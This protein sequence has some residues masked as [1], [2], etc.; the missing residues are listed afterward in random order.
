MSL[1]PHFLNST[2]AVTQ[3]RDGINFNLDEPLVFF[4]SKWGWLRT[5][6]TSDGLSVPQIFWNIIPPV[7]KLLWSGILHDGCYR[8]NTEQL[9]ADGTWCKVTF[10]ESDS[11]GLL[12][13]AARSLGGNDVEVSTIYH[14]LQWFGFRAFSDDR[15]VAT[16]NGRSPQ[17]YAALIASNPFY[18]LDLAAAAASQKPGASGAGNSTGAAPD[19]EP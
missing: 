7:G 8:N 18:S 9:Q 3:Q 10:G 15:K 11:N 19:I 16:I 6:T 13:E 12:E 5:E 4:S 1:N 2:L 17:P 14:I